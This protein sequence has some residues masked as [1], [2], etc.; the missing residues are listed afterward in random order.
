MKGHKSRRIQREM[1]HLRSFKYYLGR[2]GWFK[3]P[4]FSQTHKLMAATKS[5]DYLG[6]KHYKNAKNLKHFNQLGLAQRP[7]SFAI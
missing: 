6:L 4:V 2:L 5:S 1:L 7:Q 3:T